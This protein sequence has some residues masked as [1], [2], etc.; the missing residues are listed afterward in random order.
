M[1]AAVTTGSKSIATLAR[2]NLPA[3]IAT[4]PDTPHR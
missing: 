3:A 1:I 2:Q 4:M